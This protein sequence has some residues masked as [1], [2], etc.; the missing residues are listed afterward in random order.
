METLMVILI[1]LLFLSCLGGMISQQFFLSR[2]R[3]LHP[4][5]WDEL[6][7]P[8]LFLNSGLLN[9]I[10]FIKFMWHRGYESLP[11]GKTVAFGR[12]LRAFLIFYTILFPVTV[13]VC[14]FA[15]KPHK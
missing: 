7:K 9:S 13:F 3:K 10:R 6:G 4:A 14:V 11:D 2:L 12:F 5:T 15:I 1:P 8:V